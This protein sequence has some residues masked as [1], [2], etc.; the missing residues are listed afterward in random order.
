MVGR[1]RLDSS[2]VVL[3]HTALSFDISLVEVLIPLAGGARVVLTTE[4]QQRDPA[5]LIRLVNDQHITLLQATPSQ[6]EVLLRNGYR[7]HPQILAIAGGEALSPS[8]AEAIR[9]QSG[10][11]LNGYGPTEVTIYASMQ[12]ME[13]H[14]AIDIG[15]P[16]ANT[17]AMVLDRHGHP[18]PIGIAG[19]LFLGGCGVARGYRNRAELTRERCVSPALPVAAERR[20][21]HGGAAGGA[22]GSDRAAFHPAHFVRNGW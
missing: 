9:Q 22:E 16:L 13:A 5:A 12:T 2:A 3:A 8:L 10:A 21:G 14:S 11:L 6:W 4:E 19:E 18:C 17:S 15:K 1:L 7:Q 20:A